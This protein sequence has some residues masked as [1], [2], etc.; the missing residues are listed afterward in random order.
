[1]NRFS[2]IRI[3]SAAIV[4]A[5]LI[6]LIQPASAGPGVW[7]SSGPNGGRV[8]GLVASPF[9][10]NEYYAVTRGG[11]FKTIDGG[12]NWTDRS[13]G[14]NRQVF[15]IVHSTTA[16]NRLMVSG[17][18][19]VFFSDDGALT[20]SD[21]T[22]PASL[23]AAER[24]GTLAASKVSPGTYFLGLNDDR[25]LQTSDSGLTWTAL[26]PIPQ[27]TD[28]SIS[29]IAS[30]PSAAADLL[31][32]TETDSA[33]GDHRLWRGDLSVSPVV[34]TEIPCPATCIWA[35]GGISG[36]EFGSAGRV[37]AIA[38]SGI[39]RSDDSGATW[40][41]PGG[42]FNVP[43][44]ALAI[45]PGDNTEVYVSGHI[46]LSY[47]TDD[48]VSWTDIQ[49]GFVGNN[50]LQPAQS[51]A[52]VYNP[53]NPAIQLAGTISN[54][55]Y[56]RTSTVLDVFERGVNGFNALII[57]AVQTNTGDRVHAGVGDSFGSTF[58]SFISANNGASWAE[59]N[60][61]LAA[62]QF[63]A[64][65]VDPNDS[66]I[67]YAG[68][69]FSPKNNGVSTDP[70]NGGIY[71]STNGGLTWS[72]IDNGI[73]LTPPPFVR[74]LFRT[75][76]DIEVD[77][78]SAGPMGDSQILYAGGSGRFIDDGM[79]GITKQ[80]ARIF[81]SID[82]GANWL[83]SDTGIG[84]AEI[85]INGFP[86]FASVVQIIQDTTDAT[87]NTLYAATFI[88]GTNPADVLTID[89]GV[90]KSMDAGATWSN[91]STGL[92]RLGGL[93]GNPSADV[94]SLAYDPTDVTGQT[95]YAS[96][97]DFSSGAPLGSV[98]KTIN[99]GISWAFS[100]TG[101]ANR[102]VRDLIVDPVTGDVYA[103]V[104]DPLSNGDGGVFV[105][106]DGGASWSSISTGFPG[107]AVA[108]KLALDNTASN[109]LI[110]AG[111]T[112]GI[113]SFEV[114]PDGDIDGAPNPIEGNAPNGGDGNLDGTGDQTQ[115]NVA[116]PT[117]NDPFR[118]GTSSY[119][120]ASLTG[121]SGTCAGLQD[122][123]G[124]DLLDQ[125]PVESALDAP[126]N[127]LHLRIPD[128][129]QAEV[130]LIY[131]GADFSDPSFGMR[132]YGLAFPD[133]DSNTWHAIPAMLNGTSWTFTLSDGA[134]GDATPDDGIIVFQG[135][136][137]HLVEAFFSD[138]MEAE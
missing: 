16:A 77:Q 67:I 85:G 23:L 84:G 96:T 107:A 101:L 92:P 114:I 47:T 18:T 97:N 135:A 61:G 130:E 60:N 66:D 109:L 36:M 31:V 57:R 119:I 39:A 111:T 138:S 100:G 131:H 28:F 34:W 11:V 99:G 9:N 126:F 33:I 68:G 56:R 13:A 103:A 26:T 40:T 120:T 113:Q 50:L 63:R 20:W 69:L 7:T 58:A 104:V 87:G 15:Q 94:L 51:T 129:E 44:L 70:G 71:K 128:C 82:A 75:V 80:S 106:S 127:G 53:A 93:V 125:V 37:W 116:S 25:V 55:V 38:Q 133:Q 62:D 105:S 78:F 2:S 112:R 19:K 64:L 102:D 134:P 72:T 73:P 45:N 3:S 8:A 6:L 83:P 89:N 4:L 42:L 65:T 88:G 32:A 14:I 90:F 74:S 117:V 136:A 12:V 81:K 124:L 110:Q 54:G 22:P 41:T 5:A 10:V 123:F 48:G 1:M 27:P 108:V 49:S 121:I 52:V 29:A 118:R 35:D 46:G 98:Y 91:V 137:K 76:R 17:A 24:L 122:S 95:L 86:L 43:G 59:A 79:G 21:R 132:A 115:A 30:N